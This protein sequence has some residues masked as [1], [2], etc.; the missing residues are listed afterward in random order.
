MGELKEHF[1]LGGLFRPTGI[2]VTISRAAGI[3]RRWVRE[4]GEGFRGG[5]S[6][7]YVFNRYTYIGRLYGIRW[8][9]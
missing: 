2:N 8:I 7:R 4:R 3:D 1:C 9:E 5:E 6:E